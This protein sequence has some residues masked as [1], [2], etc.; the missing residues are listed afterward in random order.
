MSTTNTAYYRADRLEALRARARGG[1]GRAPRVSDEIIRRAEEALDR[2]PYSVVHK[3]TLPPSGNIHDYWH[4]SPYAWP[5]PDT[6]DGLPYVH[7]DGQRVPGTRLYEAE[8]GKYDRTALQRL[9]DESTIHAL[10]WY[11]TGRSKYAEKS[12]ELIRT[13]FI[14]EATAMTP[15]LEYSQVVLGKNGNRGRNYGVIETKDLYFCLDAVRLIE[16][17]SAWGRSDDE[18]MRA[19]CRTFLNWLLK[20]EQGRLE[21]ETRN[22][23]GVCYDLQVAALAAYLGDTEVLEE[24]GRSARRRLRQHIV[25]DGRQPHELVRTATFHY[26]AFNLQSWLNLATLLEN[27]IGLDLWHSEVSPDHLLGGVVGR[28][29]PHRLG[30][31]CAIE[32]ALYWLLPYYRKSWEYPQID[33]FNRE[34]LVPL[35]YGALGKFPALSGV[36]GQEFPPIE[37]A[38]PCYFPHDGIPVFWMISA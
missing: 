5:N 23:H 18:R 14:E 17:S 13:W 7:R 31:Y 10:A 30:A 19:W 8:S 37:R 6:P 15:H 4:P 21:K 38:E 22:N 24:V 29:F 16:S 3:T 34:R 36:F 1:E 27:S 28:L 25:R 32:R 33:E 20:S 2:G 9:F 12:A 35:Y 26:C 11:L